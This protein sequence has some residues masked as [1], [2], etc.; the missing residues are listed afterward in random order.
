MILLNFVSNVLL[1]AE[2]VEQKGGLFDVN[3][4]LP[5]MAVQFIVFV[6]ILNVI[7]FKPLTKAIDDRDDY[8]RAQIIGAKERLEK[9]ELVVKQYEQ[10]LAA[11]RKATQNVL[12]NAQ[13]S[14]NKIR[15]ERIDAATAEAR[16]KVASAKAEIEKQKQ[17][18][19]ASLDAEVDSLSRQVLEKLLGN[20]VRS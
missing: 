7:F 13:A 14:A 2:A 3:A 5:I 6:A 18:A 8:V 12:A 11:A 1:A 16:A 9:S 4:T 10:E 15:K 17:D 19:T 20:L